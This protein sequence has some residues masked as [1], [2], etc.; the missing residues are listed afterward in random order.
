M[1]HI[2]MDVDYTTESC[3]ILKL[4]VRY[5]FSSETLNRYLTNGKGEN[6]ILILVAFVYIKPF[7]EVISYDI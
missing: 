3:T 4:E 7:K 6:N 1:L 2:I 5:I